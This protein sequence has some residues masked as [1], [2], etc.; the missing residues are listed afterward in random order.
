MG[1]KMDELILNFLNENSTPE[2]Y[3]EIV[4]CI[5]L[6]EQFG[7]EDTQA[8]LLNAINAVEYKGSQLVIDDIILLLESR[9]EA[10]FISIR[11]TISDGMNYVQKKELLK[12]ILEL[13][14]LDDT[15]TALDIINHLSDS[16]EILAELLEYKTGVVSDEYL[17][18]ID[19]ACPSLI[20]RL[21]D[22]YSN[23]NHMKD[24][25]DDVPYSV[26]KEKIEVFKHLRNFLHDD[27]GPMTP[28]FKT[29][30]PIGLEYSYYLDELSKYHDDKVMPDYLAKSILACAIISDSDEDPCTLIRDN[31][32]LLDINIGIA[33]RRE[34]EC[35]KLN[36]AFQ[37]YL[38]EQKARKDVQV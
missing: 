38:N 17:Q 4:E 11:V 25:L 2:H 7:Y 29:D 24:R 16:T 1:F 10:I 20:S 8:M 26:G 28:Y 6:V 18:L 32:E 35:R 33:N 9:I 34:F 3:Q 15:G 5:D 30:F 36:T 21:K 22:I 37:N 12:N 14:Y 13:E 27:L 31:L 19:K 23:D